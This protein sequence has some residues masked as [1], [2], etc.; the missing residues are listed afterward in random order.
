MVESLGVMSLPPARVTA[1]IAAHPDDEIIGCGSLLALRARERGKI[2]VLV[3]TDGSQL[4][5]KVL[6]IATNPTPEEVGTR[7][8]NESVNAGKVIGLPKEAYTFW[9]Y[10]DGKLNAHKPEVEKRL[11]A[12]FKEKSPDEIFCHRDDDPHADHSMAASISHHA[13]ARAAP[14]VPVYQFRVSN[15]KIKPTG[16]QLNIPAELTSLKRKALNCF[17]SHL[18]RWSPLQDRP[19][20]ENWDNY[21]SSQEQF[22][23]K[24]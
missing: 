6:G 15:E 1:V 5:S 14:Q 7:R 12:W 9:N 21:L 20:L 19:I 11:I 10:P 22:E 4:F 17:R 2:W 13:A 16:G 23:I 8:V 3:L 18:D 24:K